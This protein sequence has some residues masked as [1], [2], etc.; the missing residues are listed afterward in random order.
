MAKV[1]LNEKL[2][3]KDT[4]DGLQ[5]FHGIS[6][7]RA[8][9]ICDEAFMEKVMDAMFDAQSDV[10]CNAPIKD[11]WVKSDAVFVVKDANVE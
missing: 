3:K 6:K 5:Q 7:K 10:I 1:I 2:L 4:I 11:K 8:K 9:K